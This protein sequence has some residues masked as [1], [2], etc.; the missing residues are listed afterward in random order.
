MKCVWLSDVH[1]NFLKKNAFIGFLRTLQE[2][3]ADAVLLSGDIAEAQRLCDY[4]FMIDIA[5]QTKIHFVLGNHDFYRGSIIR[6]RQAVAEL[7]QDSRYLVY[8]TSPFKVLGGGQTARGWTF[9]FGQ[10]EWIARMALAVCPR[11]V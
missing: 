4:L 9:C 5:L 10:V 2:H 6:T 3:E 7:V 11:R 8:L 1:L